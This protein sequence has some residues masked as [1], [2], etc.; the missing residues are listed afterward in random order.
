MSF[1]FALL[2]WSFFKPS[3]WLL[4]LS[5]YCTCKSICFYSFS[6]CLVP[7]P[8]CILDFTSFCKEKSKNPALPSSSSSLGIDYKTCCLL[9]TSICSLPISFLLL[10]TFFNFSFTSTSKSWSSHF[11]IL[12][13]TILAKKIFIGTPLLSNKTN[14]FFLAK[15]EGFILLEHFM[16]LETLSSPWLFWFWLSWLS[17][18]LIDSLHPTP[19]AVSCL[20]GSL[21]LRVCLC[22]FFLSWP[23]FSAGLL[24]VFCMAFTTTLW[25]WHMES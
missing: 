22:K 17:S 9:F 1:L 24:L 16:V 20:K 7:L 10:F 5:K 14:D 23:L 4:T 11:K 2:I 25:W 12:N 18:Y 3:I 15:F 21:P 6:P 8:S 19:L 13:S